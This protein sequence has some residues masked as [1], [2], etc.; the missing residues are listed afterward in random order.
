MINNVITIMILKQTD[1]L[2][3]NVVIGGFSSLITKMTV[4]PLYRIRTIN[5]ANN[6]SSP[7]QY[8]S[9]IYKTEGYLG[10]YK[11]FTLIALTTLP[12][13]GITYSSARYFDNIFSGSYKHFL[14]GACAGI[15]TT[16]IFFPID[17]INTQK[18]YKIQNTKYSLTKMIYPFRTYGFVIF[19]AMTHSCF[20][21]GLYTT[22]NNYLKE[23]HKNSYF[24]SFMIGYLAELIT[25][26]FT[27]PLDTIRKRLYV[28]NMNFKTK[29]YSGYKYILI[30]SPISSG[31]FYLSVELLKNFI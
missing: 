6:G 23:H 18:I 12:K 22:T 26:T 11:N 19:G 27:Y 15:I 7:F 14:S 10:F 31:I 8:L 28:N 20:N 13:A 25:V 21:Y 24:R 3:H 9:H 1:Q 2:Y 4:Y 29:L 5:Q 30:K 17:V 16:S